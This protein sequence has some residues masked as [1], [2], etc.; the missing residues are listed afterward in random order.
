MGQF[1]LQVFVG[2]PA[3][4][5]LQRGDVIVSIEG[6]QTGYMVHKQ[7]QDIIKAAGG[8]LEL[9]VKRYVKNILVF[10]G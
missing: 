1:W 7:A 9:C 4:G 8:T 5:E 3:D 6:R 2:S 10:Q